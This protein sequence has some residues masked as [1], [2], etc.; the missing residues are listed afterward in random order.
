[1]DTSPIASLAP[2]QTKTMSRVWPKRLVSKLVVPIEVSLKVDAEG[3]V[4]VWLK[5]IL[6]EQTPKRKLEF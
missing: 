2:Q 1:M 6:V 5:M 3:H 4:H